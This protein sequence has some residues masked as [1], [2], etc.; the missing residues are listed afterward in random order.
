MNEQYGYTIIWRSYFSNDI[1]RKTL[2][3]MSYQQCL[4]KEQEMKRMGYKTR[5]CKLCEQGE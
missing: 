1:W 5:I 4:L 3:N 2:I